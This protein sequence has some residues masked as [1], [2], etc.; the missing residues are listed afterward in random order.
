[1]TF[2]FSDGNGDPHGS[3]DG[4]DRHSYRITPGEDMLDGLYYGQENAYTHA[5]QKGGEASTEVSVGR[6]VVGEVAG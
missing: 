6:E 2:R 5:G 3:S 1:M 4:G